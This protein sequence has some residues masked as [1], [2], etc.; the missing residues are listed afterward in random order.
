MNLQKSAPIQPR[1]RLPTF[2]TKALPFSFTLSGFLFYSPGISPVHPRVLSS[3]SEHSCNRVCS[4]SC[5]ELRRYKLR[6]ARSRLYRRR[7]L[8]VNTRWKAL[9]EIY[10]MY[11]FAPF[12]NRIPKNEENHGGKR[13]W[14]NPGKTGQEKLISSRR[15]LLSTQYSIA[16]NC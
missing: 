7:F 3:L 4:H 14:S 1:T 11:S 8:Q 6:G 5:N 10:T 15:S 2:G 13:T 16:K 9:A 12:W